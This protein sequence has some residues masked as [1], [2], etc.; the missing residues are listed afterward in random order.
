MR[1]V[2]FVGRVVDV[3][4]LVHLLLMVMSRFVTLEAACVQG[5]SWCRGRLHH[6]SVW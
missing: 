3:A 2:D 1:L 5:V 6:V 4:V